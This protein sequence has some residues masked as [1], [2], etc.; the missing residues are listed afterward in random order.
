LWYRGYFND[1]SFCES[2]LDSILDF[3]GKKR[4]IV[5]HTPGSEITSMYKNKLLGIDSGIGNM[6]PG[7]MLIIK[8]GILYKGKPS[9]KRI[10]L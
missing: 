6:Q 8:Y 9:G 4:I 5:G 2:R 3:Y 7:E 10:K 1:K